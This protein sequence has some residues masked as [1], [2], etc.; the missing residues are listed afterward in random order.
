MTIPF[1]TGRTYSTPEELRALFWHAGIL[2]SR[3]PQEYAALIH[4]GKL[5]PFQSD[6][7]SAYGAQ[8]VLAAMYG[9]RAKAFLNLFESLSFKHD[10]QHW[11]GDESGLTRE[12][13][14]N[15]LKQQLEAGG[16]VLAAKVVH[17]FVDR[18]SGSRTAPYRW[19]FGW[20]K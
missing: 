5:L 11:L 6:G 13:S 8:Y 2:P 4:N 20:V 1:E 15:V 9:K 16:F 19:G 17:Q 7:P 12:Q 3:S 14:N 18:F 10:V